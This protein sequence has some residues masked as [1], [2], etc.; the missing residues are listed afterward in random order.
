MNLGTGRLQVW[1][2]TMSP[3]AACF[4][5]QRVEVDEICPI[6][7]SYMDDWE[8]KSGYSKIPVSL[9]WA[10]VILNDVFILFCR[11]LTCLTNV[12]CTCFLKMAVPRSRLILALSRFSQKP[13]GYLYY[14]VPSQLIIL[15]YIWLS[16]TELLASPAFDYRIPTNWLFPSQSCMTWW[17]VSIRD[18]KVLSTAEVLAGFDVHLLLAF[19]ISA[20]FPSSHQ[21]EPDYL[22]VHLARDDWS[23]STCFPLI[24]V[25]GWYHMDT[26]DGH[27]P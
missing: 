12:S 17:Q 3:L 21:C 16:T 25:W 19:W 10:N 9:V 5:W 22:C 6:D 2:S 23:C 1:S 7:D 11:C 8:E 13:Q 4:Q 14:H 27:D 20:L 18:K 26:E 15:C 24:C